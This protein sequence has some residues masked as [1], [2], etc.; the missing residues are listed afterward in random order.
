MGKNV[1]KSGRDVT[2]V[3]FIHFPGGTDEN[4]DKKI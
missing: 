3:L 1:E 2:G 4:H